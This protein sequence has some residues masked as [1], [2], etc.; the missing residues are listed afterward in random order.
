MAMSGP[1]EM[2][3]L[4][5]MS[6]AGQP[7]DLVSLLPPQDY[8]KAQGIEASTD[9]LLELAAKD[10]ADG[11]TQFAQ[12]LAIRALSEDGD[13]KKSANY[14]AGRKLLEDIAAG[15]KAQDKLGFAKEYAQRAL[16]QLEGGKLPAAAQPKARAEGLAW[17]PATATLVAGIESAPAPNA[18]PAKNP[19]PELVKLLPA[20]VKK[21]FY[22]VASSLGNVQ[23]QRF[24][25]AFVEEGEDKGRIFMRLSGRFN[26]AWVS[27]ALNMLEKTAR[28]D[29]QGTPITVFTTLHGPAI[30]LVGNH[31]FLVCGFAGK[32]KNEE[33][34]EQALSLRDEKQANAAT[35]ALKATL[36][37]IPVKA[38]G[39]LVGDFPEDG[40]REFTR[41]LGA[42]PK[43]IV[44]H[45]ER[46]PTGLE[47]FANGTMDDDG[48]AKTFVQTASKLRM[49]AITGL[50]NAPVIPVP[51][52]NLE[53]LKNVLNSMQIEAKGGG[54]TIRMLV[55]DDALKTIP[56]LMFGYL[57]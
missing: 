46:G 21:E 42:F 34:L 4:L 10:P 37:K 3:L 49:D 9:K 24:T 38:V 39:F 6:A 32:G 41:S 33:V 11:P 30:G 29:G 45:V 51:G 17:F 52:A 16:A 1:M 40:R 18:A 43:R 12:L 47:F 35:G 23:L 50:Q 31:D 26:H 28:Q 15:K 13:F 20:E 25:M 14:A 7:T 8:F 36:D 48:Q 57:R 56:A 5:T 19:A 44:A 55:S 27:D 2:L 53:E 54:I 22:K